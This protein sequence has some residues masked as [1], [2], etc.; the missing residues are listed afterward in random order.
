MPLA[1]R[2]AALA[3]LLV[4]FAASAAEA[5]LPWGDV[6]IPYDTAAWRTGRPGDG[7]SG[8]VLTCIAA[9]CPEG[10]LIYASIGPPNGSVEEERWRGPVP[11]ALHG[12]ALPFLAYQLWSGCRALDAPILSAAVVFRERR[13]RLVTALG[14][15]CN[16][17]PQIPLSRFTDL[18]E[19]IRPAS[20]AP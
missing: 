10:G 20:G 11:I 1:A 9:D 13:Y 5:V 14:A 17:G 19:G 2:L 3:L 7:A 6:E 4:P 8:L 18:V 15:G 16:F 12:P